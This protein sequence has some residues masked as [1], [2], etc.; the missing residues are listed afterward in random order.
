MNHLLDD[1]DNPIGRPDRE[2]TLSTGAILGIFFGLVLIC[3]V[4]FAFGY[5][6]GQK[7]KAPVT[8]STDSDTSQTTLSSHAKPSAGSLGDS[9]IPAQAATTPATQMPLTTTPPVAAATRTSRPEPAPEPAA[10]PVPVPRDQPAPVAIQSQ[11]PMGGPGMFIVQIAAVSQQGDAAMLVGALR[12]K[13]YAVAARTE[14]DNLIHI[15]VGPFDNK[16]QATAMRDRLLADGYN[17]I[18][19]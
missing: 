7:S 12:Q 3:G 19:K 9:V 17:A 1:D 14:P 8:S 11:A 15:Q 4:F 16:A 13:G 2:L 5:N 10:A 18:V 6:L